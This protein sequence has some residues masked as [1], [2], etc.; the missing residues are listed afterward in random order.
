VSARSFS[1]LLPQ[2]HNGA[3]TG[4][5][6]GGKHGD[7]LVSVKVLP[8]G[9]T[10]SAGTATTVKVSAGLSFVVTVE[11]SGDSKEIN[12]PVTLTIKAGGT[13]IVRRHPITL[14]QPA[15]QQTVTFSN[16][17]LP[18]SAFGAKATIKVE[19]GHVPGEINTGNNSGTYTVFFTLSSP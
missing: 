14:I 12:V 13:P 9:D 10:L 2:I 1:V 5:T 6:P 3:S 4:G 19:V 17:D 16:F 8:Q 7:A 18:T 15:E 11:D